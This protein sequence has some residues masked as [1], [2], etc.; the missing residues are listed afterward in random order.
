MNITLYFF[1]IMKKWFTLVEILMVMW[2]IA[3]LI[4]AISFFMPNNGDKKIKFG[5]ECSN[6]IYQEIVNE[7]NSVQ[8]NKTINSWWIIYNHISSDIMGDKQ[9][10]NLEIES[11]YW[12][13]KVYKELINWKWICSSDYIWN[14]NNYL[15]KTTKWFLIQINKDNIYVQ[16]NEWILT[17]CDIDWKNCIEISKITF[18]Q[19]TWKLEQKNCLMFSWSDCN[20]W[21]Q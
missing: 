13:Q 3:L 10:L 6:Y 9:K 4:W 16:D 7:L 5:K 2:I 14:Q 18:N 15:I 21:E 20:E 1:I 8:K 11:N 19:A 12:D 17:V